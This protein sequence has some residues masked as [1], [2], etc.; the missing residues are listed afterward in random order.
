M[1]P[2]IALFFI[3]VLP[4]ISLFS[5]QVPEGYLLQYQQNFNGSKVLA[6]FRTENADKWGIFKNGPNFYLECA[7]A[8]SAGTLPSNIAVL[9]N[10]VFGD[11][12]MEAEIMAGLDTAGTGDVCLF[13]GMRYPSKYY[14]IQLSN[15]D[16]SLHN[17]IFLLRN[18]RYGKLEANA[19]KPISWDKN[20]WH[21]IRLE[22][23]IISRTIRIYVDNMTAPYLLTKDYNLIMGSIGFGSFSG[24]ARFDN[25]KIWAPTML[26]EEELKEME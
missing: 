20:K 2:T 13:L 17:G 10:R 8:D 1:K 5:Q 12:I 26:T 23:N 25:I 3:L 24:M 11:F 21:K 6:D 15:I 18:G 4:A 7:A 14:V 22:R 19:A 9:G 16:D